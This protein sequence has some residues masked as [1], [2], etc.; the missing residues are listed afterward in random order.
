MLNRAGKISL[1]HNSK[2]AVCMKMV[3]DIENES[4]I[5]GEVQFVS[6]VPFEL[7]RSML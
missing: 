2:E 7:V 1:G 6:V 4:E 3:T 5:D